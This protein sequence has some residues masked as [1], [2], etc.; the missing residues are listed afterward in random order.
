MKSRM[1]SVFGSLPLLR[2]ITLVLVTFFL[3]IAFYYQLNGSQFFYT[4]I[5][6]D[7]LI[8]SEMLAGEP[9]LI[10]A[11]TSL[12]GVFHGPLWVYLNFPVFM[13]SGGNPVAHT[14]YWMGLTLLFICS[15]YVVTKKLFDEKAAMIAVV[16]VSINMIGFASFYTNPIGALFTLP[17]CLYFIVR[18]WQTN[19]AKYLMAHLLCAGAIVHFEM[20]IGVPFIFLTLVLCAFLWVRSKRYVHFLSFFVLLIPLSTF[21]VFDVRHEFLQLRSVFNYVFNKGGEFS[22]HR[23]FQTLFMQRFNLAT[24]QALGV[25]PINRLHT[26][27]EGLNI[28]T[29]IGFFLFFVKARREKW[30]KHG[31]Y[32]IFAFYYVG[33]F[34]LTFVLRDALL[35][36]YAYPLTLLPIMLFASLHNKI[37]TTFFWITIS[38]ALI[39]GVIFGFNE[40]GNTRQLMAHSE[41]DWKIL[42]QASSKLFEGSESEL[43]YFVY[44]PDVFAYQQKYAVHYMS[45][46]SEKQVFPFQKRRITYLFIASPSESMKEVSAAD[47]KRDKLHIDTRHKPDATFSLSGGYT[48]EKYIF[49]DEEVKVPVDFDVS[50][51]LFFR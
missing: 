24:N 19:K 43:G 42:Q 17:A 6:R 8:Q 49:T 48:V 47:W 23:T 15:I 50:S 28:L 30:Q 45:Q 27:F 20:M 35:F 36:H 51:A 14:Q 44:A 18:Y 33:Y 1:H 21:I 46:Q 11:R 25:F 9:T 39:V 22:S 10:G 12:Q 40:I 38:I 3:V 32:L 7:M 26:K 29:L 16:L 31:I 41:N 34:L 13:L 4:D 5:G 2:I 37:N